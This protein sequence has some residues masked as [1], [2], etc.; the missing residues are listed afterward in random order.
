MDFEQ[1]KTAV[2]SRSSNPIK[3]VLNSFEYG[4]DLNKFCRW[5]KKFET[6][7]PSFSD[8]LICYIICKTV[9][10][11]ETCRTYRTNLPSLQ[12]SFATSSS[13][14]MAVFYETVS[15]CIIL[16]LCLLLRSCGKDRSTMCLITNHELH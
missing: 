12:I 4:H 8:C 11:L 5:K 1:I 6:S 16:L 14:M 2:Q 9:F 7:I 15:I 13:N 10:E 3:N